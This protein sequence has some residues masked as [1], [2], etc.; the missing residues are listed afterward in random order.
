M[1]AR[2]V[3]LGGGTGLAALLSSIKHLPL[4]HL[5]A[6]VTVTDDGGST[7]RLRRELDVPAVG[8]IRNCL[9]ALAEADVL[10]ARLFDL[11][12]D[13]GGELSGH[14]F[15]NIFLAGL[16]QITGDLPLAVRQSAEILT[17]RG[18]I[19]P[20][21]PANVQL[22]GW[23]RDGRRLKGECSV[24]QDGPPERVALD[25][26]DP[27]AVPEA[28]EAIRAADLILLG[29]GSLLWE[30]AGDPRGL[31]V[32]IANL[33]TQEDETIGLSLDGHLA[34]LRH[35][36]HG[37]CPDA[38]LVNSVEPSPDAVARYAEERA[39]PLLPSAD[40]GWAEPAEVIRWPLL[41][42][43]EGGYL[44]HDRT[45]LAAAVASLLGEE[46]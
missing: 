37:L 19:V 29:P 33:M 8:D 35:H 5:T 10:L 9:V 23:D 26:A 41:A 15:G 11:R 12:F 46:R 36:G 25:P 27:P 17:I 45:Q 28:T 42:Q 3:A 16:A 38:L 14:A 32:W 4:D 21:T 30:T 18:T 1:G 6:V 34:A 2:V 20:S 39:T 7:G 43:T 31:L 44:R 22:V 13:T 24:T 40:D